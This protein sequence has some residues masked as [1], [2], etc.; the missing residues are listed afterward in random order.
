MAQP[1]GTFSQYDAA[2]NREDLVNFIY[3]V[4]P[5]E[6]PVVSMVPRVK[7]RNVTHEWQIDALAAAASNA[8]VE[9][10]AA[11]A[12]SLTATSRLSNKTQI[13]AKSSI[14][15][16]TQLAMNPAGRAD[17]QAYQ[18]QKIIKECKRDLETAVCADVAK[19][20]GNDSTARKMAGISTW[21]K[22][23]FSKDSGG[24]LPTGDGTD[25][26]TEGTARVLTEDLVSDALQLAFT[27]GGNP[28]K[29]ICGAFNR[30]KFSQFAGNSMRVDKGEDRRLNAGIDIYVGDF[31][32]ID[33]VADR[34]SPTDR[35]YLLDPEMLKLAV[36]RDWDVKDMAISG[37]YVSQSVYWE[38]TLEMCNEKAHAV[39][40]DLTT[41]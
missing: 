20:T 15:T 30:R 16:N 21:L 32:E 35:I 10:D 11:P 14:V 2:G 19:V 27:N 29:A 17:E 23:N 41:S 22:T 39:V 33:I 24:T 12:P 8:Q 28:T 36:L 38:G 7:A 5:T 18:L 34:F 40:H 4:S 6:T 3:D 25:A 9:G 13:I 31:H 26:Y 1:S 37:D